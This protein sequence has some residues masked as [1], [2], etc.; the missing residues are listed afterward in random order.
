MAT[1][2]ISINA[3]ANI[4]KVPKSLLWSMMHVINQLATLTA[5]LRADHA[6]LRTELIAIGVT[7]ADYKTE[8]DAHTHTQ[9][10]GDGAQ[11]SIPDDTA[12]GI[13]GAG[14][15]RVFTDTSGGSVPATLAAGAADDFTTRELGLPT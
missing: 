15:D 7:L 14:T 6:T 4:T 10:D 12:G 5:E 11:T 1:R 13:A 9:E 3:A 8:F 2:T